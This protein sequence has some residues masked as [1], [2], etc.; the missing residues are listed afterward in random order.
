MF[1]TGVLDPLNDVPS[2]RMPWGA[3]LI[4]GGGS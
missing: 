2:V 4:S 1:D 3:D